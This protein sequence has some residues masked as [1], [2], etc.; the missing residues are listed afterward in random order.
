MTSERPKPGRS[1]EALSRAREFAIEAARSLHDDKCLDV[2]VLD[3]SGLSQVTDF[4]VIA[5]GTSGR[6][7]ASA[8]DHVVE[9]AADRG[10]AAFG[11]STDD[12]AEW[13]LAD[14]VDVVVHVF[15]P[16]TRAH[17][18]LEMMWGDAEQVPWKRSA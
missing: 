10:M 3:V 8:L 14:L 11:T 13:F 16:N 18:D 15:E 4:I 7:M 9:L 5:S 1:P 17:Y 6:Q 2:L 12:N